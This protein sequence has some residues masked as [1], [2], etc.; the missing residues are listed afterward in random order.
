MK[1]IGNFIGDAMNERMTK[2][3]VR[4]GRWKML[5][6]SLL[7]GGHFGSNHSVIH[8]VEIG[9]EVGLFLLLMVFLG[10]CNGSGYKGMQDTSLLCRLIM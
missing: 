4:E 5:G 8:F 9:N 3:W 2:V 6:S 10:Y 7:C 1:E